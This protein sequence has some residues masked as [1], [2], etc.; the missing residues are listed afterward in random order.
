[1]ESNPNEE[2]A[3]AAASKVNPKLS[4]LTKKAALFQGRNSEMLHS[5]IKS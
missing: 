1:M 5:N 3:N 4:L 2:E